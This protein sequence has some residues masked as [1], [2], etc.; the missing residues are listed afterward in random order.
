MFIKRCFEDPTVKEIGYK[1][2]MSVMHLTLASFSLESI[3]VL[4][5]L[6]LRSLAVGIIVTFSKEHLHDKMNTWT[7]IYIGFL[8]PVDS[9]C[10]NQRHATCIRQ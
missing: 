7:F 10:F 9:V 4:N 3:A 8:P 5:S 1:P 6:H 2:F